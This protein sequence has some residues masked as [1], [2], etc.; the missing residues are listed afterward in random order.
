MVRTPC[1]AAVLVTFSLVGS[2][3]ELE[4]EQLA[5][6]ES[7][8]RPVLIQE[9]YGCHSNKTGNARGGLRL[10]TRQLIELGGE[11][12]A[13][14][15]PGDPD[16]SSLLSA[17]KYADF[18]MPPGGQL[19]QR[20]IDDFQKWIE[21]GAPD[22]RDTKTQEFR[23]GITAD[24]IADAKQEFWAYRAPDAGQLPDVQDA[25]WP[26]T[27]VDRYVLAA[28]ESSDMSPSADAQSYQ[29]LRRICVDLVGLPPSPDQ[30]DYFH[31]QWRKDPQAAV[32]LVVDRLLEMPQF[33][34]RWG[35][36]WLDV[37]RF[38]ESNGKEVNMTFPHAWRYRDYVIDSFNEDKPYDRFLQEQIAGD[39]LPAKTDEQ[40][41]SNLVATGFLAIGP[42]NLS[43]RQ[44][45]QFAADLADEQLDV[46]TRVVLGTS[47]ACARCHDHKFDPIPQTDYYALAAVFMNTKTYFGVPASEYGSFSSPQNR[48]P[49]DLI[50]LPI[51]D[52]SDFEESL[53]TEE[54]KQ[55]GDAIA[56]TRREMTASRR[57]GNGSQQDRIRL[58]LKAEALSTRLGGFDSD[59]SPISFCMGV[60]ESDS[61][62]DIRLL[63]RGEIDQPGQFVPRGFP[64]VLSNGSVDI[65]SDSSG[66]LE[67]ARWISSRENPLT[68]RVMVNRIW[69]HLMGSGIVS[70]LENFGSTGKSPSHPQLLDRL[71]IDFAEDNWSIKSVVRKIITSR[72]YRVSSEYNEVAFQQD[73]DN[74]LLWRANPRRMDAEVLRDS[75]L[76][77]A[78]AI[79][80]E[81]PR[82]SEVAKAG[83]MRV[84]D[85]NLNNTRSRLM[86]GTEMQSGRMQAGSGQ[87]LADAARRRAGQ[88]GGRPGMGSRPTP[89][90]IA[91]LTPEQRARIASRLPRGRDMQAAGPG[92]GRGM[93]GRTAPVPPAETL[94]MVDATIRS[95][96]LP[97]VRNEVPRA[98][99]VFDFADS[100]MVIGQRESSNTPNQAL[101]MM[102][103]EFV[104]AQSTN[105][106]RRVLKTETDQQKRI[107]LLFRLVYG[108]EAHP[109]E[110]SA[111]TRFAAD[112]AKT[113]SY[114]DRSLET[115]TAVCQS[116]FASAEFRYID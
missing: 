57:G 107:E 114:R 73:P 100:S 96:Y 36:H 95:V 49:S 34:E 59:G 110:L 94:D 51:E 32:E 52:P 11:S 80:L 62:E 77:I 14:V 17:M 102:N 16:A 99:E 37:V 71:A 53:S 66:R 116:L 93:A 24:D 55:L 46:T 27:D 69:M 74:R 83:Y 104:L 26:V 98:L 21:M 90:Q 22:P 63:V 70:T 10:D 76:H 56:E 113:V 40:W 31:K 19:P 109:S 112:F 42:K 9:C 12:G 97:I 60:Q 82:A 5:F 13:A 91:R 115:W 30:I 47:V 4:P 1:V 38:A 87:M 68:A 20:V 43:E 7:K 67:L 25:D 50:R 81:R 3:A 35:R 101:Y 89:E 23:S 64:Q 48:R 111:V 33:G 84:R 88:G 6:F 39:L 41:T 44:N 58:L 108:R 54:M 75:M 105:L 72:A 28:L 85:G 86:L 79:D 45:A 18:E 103:N 78:G 61:P 2:A 65:R 92:R 106:A 8:I 29:V 15:V